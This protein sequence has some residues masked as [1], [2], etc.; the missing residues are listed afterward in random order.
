MST[1]SIE[2]ATEVPEAELPDV[3]LPKM[4][5]NPY[6]EFGLL[7]EQAPVVRGRLMASVPAWYVTRYEDV[8]NVLGDRRFVSNIAN[9]PNFDGLDARKEMAEKM[10]ISA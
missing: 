2:T 10:G 6:L 4:M 7:R 9:V 8:M 5:A 3:L 1:D